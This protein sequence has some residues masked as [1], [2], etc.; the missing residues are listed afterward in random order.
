MTSP[1]AVVIRMMLD[2][3]D[4]ASDEALSETE[5]LSALSVLNVSKSFGSQRVL[6]NVTLSVGQSEIR[7]ICGEN[8][9]GKSTLIK[10]ISG[11]HKSDAGSISVAGK[12]VDIDTVRAAQR[13][14]IALVAQELSIVSTLSVLDNIWLG[15]EQVGLLHRKRRYRQEARAA[16]DRVGLT[17]LDLDEPVSILGMGQRQL[18]EIAR[19]LTRRAKILILDE[20]TA[21]LSDVEIKQVFA[22]VRSLKASGCTVLYI[23]HRLSEVF[24]IC[25]S[26]SILRNGVLIATTSTSELDKDVLIS[27]MLGRAIEDLY[28]PSKAIS[29]GPALVVDGLKIGIVQSLN[30]T[31]NRGTTT[32]LVGQLGSGAMDIVRALAGL[33]PDATGNVVCDGKSHRLRSVRR[34]RDAGIVFVSEDRAAEGIFL[35]LSIS[36]N[37]VVNQL[38][39]LTLLGLLRLRV[40][41]RFICDVAAR[42]GLDRARLGTSAGKLSGGNQ[43]KIAFARLIRDGAPGILLMNEPT[44]GVDV[45]ARADIYRIIRQFCE[46]GWCVIMASSDLEEALGLG[47]TI[48]TLN[49]GRKV[50]TYDRAQATMARVLSDITVD[51]KTA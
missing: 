47:D 20:P 24:E 10:I 30:L 23:T 13:L 19:S 9:A 33:S 48:V 50:S 8:G 7:A 12:R 43:Q 39:R 6:D 1:K 26:V 35:R 3:S 15:N 14:G 2:P 25:D 11:L 46:E 49:K 28:P 45:G 40:M 42:V 51:W 27:L 17:D 37:L 22:A 31:A 36:K 18:V 5:A 4:L 34:A 32:C 21:T 38:G 41:G 29:A 44:R 16:L